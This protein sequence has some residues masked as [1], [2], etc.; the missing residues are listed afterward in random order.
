MRDLVSCW[1]FITGA[2]FTFVVMDD[3]VAGFPSI[4]VWARIALVVGFA[5][6]ATCVWAIWGLRASTATAD[7]KPSEL[8]A[9]SPQAV[10]SQDLVRELTLALDHIRSIR[11]LLE[12]SQTHRQPVPPS[13]PRN[14]ELVAKYLENAQKPFLL[15]PVTPVPVERP[16]V[17]YADRPVRLPRLLR[18]RR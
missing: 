6:A 11:V 13:V 15:K 18:A 17:A 2:L 7:P 4:A 14:L 9:S 1:L 16:S 5:A 12:I 10:V 8:S 3:W